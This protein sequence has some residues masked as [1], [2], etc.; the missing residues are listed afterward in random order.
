M[1]KL[2]IEIPDGFLD[3][4]ERCG[5]LVTR[6]TKE[7]WAIEIDLAVKLIN[8]CKK[9]DLRLSAEGGTLLGAVRHQGFIPWDDDIDFYLPRD[10]YD[11]LCAV[12]PKEFSYPYSLVNFHADPNFACGV[13]KLMN[14]ST[15]GYENRYFKHHGIFIDIF[16][17]DK[18]SDDDKEIESQ[19]KNAMS[20]FKKY[21]R[22][23]TCSRSDYWKESNISLPR[24]IVRLYYYIK[25][26]CLNRKVGG[27]YQK[28]LYERFEKECKKFNHLNTKRCCKVTLFSKRYN[29][30]E[31]FSHITETKFEFTKFPI[32]ENYDETL[33]VQYGDW[34]Q[35]VKGGSL[36]TFQIIDTDRPYPV[37]LGEKG[38]KY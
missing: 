36:H 9:Y 23:V 34:H 24:R 11:K 33:S 21:Q 10:D 31:D 14:E 7:V 19:Y 38:I 8:V 4:E 15:T 26:K 29:K 16:P 1:V 30:C 2:D 20:L 17:V 28:R 27:E 12:A 5:H 32:I 25:L 37:V 13:A 35:F 18:W 3:E 6:Q 22:V